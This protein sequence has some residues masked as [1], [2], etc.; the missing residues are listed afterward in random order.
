MIPP[1]P[2]AGVPFLRMVS[3]SPTPQR[4]LTASTKPA[5]AESMERGT[6]FCDAASTTSCLPGST[7]G[8]GRTRS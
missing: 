4:D 7:P 1:I 2:T 5:L 3:K 8:H 6:G